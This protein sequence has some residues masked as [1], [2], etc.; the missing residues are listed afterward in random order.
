VPSI[1]FDDVRR[2]L[3]T[4]YGLRAWPFPRTRSGPLLDQQSR[5][6]LV[7]RI[8]CKIR[9]LARAKSGGPDG[10]AKSD[11]IGAM[12]RAHARVCGEPGKCRSIWSRPFFS[13][14]AAEKSTSFLDQQSCVSLVHI[15]SKLVQSGGLVGI[16]IAGL[17]PEVFAPDQLDANP[18]PLAV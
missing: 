1:V 7:R 9:K 2:G 18:D 8:Y 15:R 14:Q 11:L 6:H 12:L 4:G 17:G 16:P 5:K 13:S 10:P 3:G